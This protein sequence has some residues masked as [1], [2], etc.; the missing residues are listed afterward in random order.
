LGGECPCR[1]VGGDDACG[2][3]SIR[4]F[5]VID[6]EALKDSRPITQIRV[7]AGGIAVNMA[8]LLFA[9]LALQFGSSSSLITM[10][11]AVTQTP[12]QLG[13]ATWITWAWGVV[14]ANAVI[15][16]SNVLP[17]VYHDGGRLLR[18]AVHGSIDVDSRPIDVWLSILF[19]PAVF[20]ILFAGYL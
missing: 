18:V 4:F 15:I 7:L 12:F 11:A 5:V 1:K 2:S 8:L 19:I 20:V 9:L 10:F 6:D 17:L 3:H 13:E 14:F 16:I